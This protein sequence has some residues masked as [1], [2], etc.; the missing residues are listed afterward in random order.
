[1]Q[2]RRKQFAH[3]SMVLQDLNASIREQAP[4]DAATRMELDQGLC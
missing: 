2:L 4:V 3:L 1:V